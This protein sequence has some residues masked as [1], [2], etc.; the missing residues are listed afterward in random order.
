MDRAR[1][2]ASKNTVL[3][4]H[5]TRD[6]Q[7][8]ECCACG[9]PVVVCCGEQ[10]QYFRHKDNSHG[11][12]LGAGDEVAV[13]SYSSIM[14]RK[15]CYFVPLG[16][17]QWILKE[18]KSTFEASCNVRKPKEPTQ[19]NLTDSGRV[20]A[21]KAPLQAV[22]AP[23][24]SA[25]DPTLVESEKVYVRGKNQ[26]V[27][28]FQTPDIG[29]VLIEDHSRIFV[30]RSYYM[31]TARTDFK[32][33][34]QVE[35]QKE[36]QTIQGVQATLL[37]MPDSWDKI[38]RNWIKELDYYPS[39]EPLTI[40]SGTSVT[41]SPQSEH[42]FFL[43][44]IETGGICPWILLRISANQIE[45]RATKN[46]DSSPIIASF[47]GKTEAD[48]Q[49]P[50]YFNIKSSHAILF[51]KSSHLTY[52]GTR[53]SATMTFQSLDQAEPRDVNLS[54]ELNTETSQ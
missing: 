36:L 42:K 34:D 4:D 14:R 30:S 16:G 29:G 44:S 6:D 31:V 8:Y 25:K 53:I 28:L 38:T 2:T 45:W 15:Y 46:A 27:H 52:P 21:E 10:R 51:S 5:A 12:D 41:F 17:G 13:A 54:I 19:D 50:I 9:R 26:N 7:L 18:L 49:G 48:A 43:V 35:I 47:H 1:E 40:C 32:I 24:F 33:P 37:K 3:I 11:C 22:R 23:G 20:E 39:D